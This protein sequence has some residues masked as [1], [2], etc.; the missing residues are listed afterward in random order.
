MRQLLPCPRDERRTQPFF[1]LLGRPGYH[2]V[3]TIPAGATNIEVKQRNHRGARHDGSFLA[4]KAADGTYVLNGDYTLSTLEQDITYK[5]S[6]LR[7]SGSS[8][9]LERIRSFSPLKE[10]LTIQ[11]LTVGDL[12]QPKIKFTYFVKKPAQPAS[13]KVPSK[14]KESFNAIK[15][16]ISSEWVIEEWGECSKSCGSGWQRRAV[17]CRDPRGRP[18]TDCARELKPSDIRPCA[19]IP[20]PQW[21]LGDWSA[22]SKTCGK[23]FKKRLL[24]CISYDGGV[25]PQESC[26]P[27]KKPKHLIDFCNVTDCS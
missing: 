10:P 20:C 26:E 17:E 8:A 12:P 25:L 19:D 4:I 24:K 13:E 6:V 11:V 22:C 18:A 16:I 3:V 2:D 21:Q 27:S 23:G 7:Y 9:A 15:E 1:L 5:G 14:K